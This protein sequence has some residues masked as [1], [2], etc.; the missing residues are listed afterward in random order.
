L[1]A[2]LARRRQ[3]NLIPVMF[4]S[5]RL[6]FRSQIFDVRIEPLG[7]GASECEIYRDR[8][9]LI[10]NSDHPSY[11]KAERG[12]WTEGVVLR[13]VATRLACDH[14]ST[15]DEAYSLLDEILRFAAG[16]A[17]RKAARGGEVAEAI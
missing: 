13:A 12:G 16:R 6:R 5:G 14:S 17:A 7:V 9:L 10:V 1:V 3:A 8:G 4:G 11:D 2:A 15:A